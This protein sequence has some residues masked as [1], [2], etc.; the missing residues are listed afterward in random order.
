VPSLLRGFSAPVNLTLS[1]SDRDL[2]FLMANDSDLFNRWQ[3]ANTYATRTLVQIVQ[4]MTAGKRSTRGASYAKALGAT[5]RNP[6]LEPAYRAE[7]LRLPSQSDIARE[8]ARDVDPGLIFRAHR[9]LAKVIGATL[10]DELEQVYREM[11]RDKTFSPDAAA[12]G[13]RALRNSALAMLMAR[14]A[15][16]DQK[17]LAAHYFNATNM[18]DQAFALFHL[19]QEATPDRER[20]L[21][22]FYDRW[23][24]DHLVIDMWFSAQAQSAL[25]SALTDVEALTKHPLFSLTA[26]NKVRAL[27][28][29]FALMNPVQFN[30]PDGAGYMFVINQVLA[31][32]GFNPQ[33]AARML[34]AFRSWRTLEP[35]RRRLARKALTKVAKSANLSRDVFEIVSRTL[36]A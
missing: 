9:Q 32:D 4:A 2:E 33:I 26:P 10:G 19:A 23:K 17:R 31:I 21:A 11:G 36:E 27:V 6:D 15:G 30:R 3:A 35:E 5:L 29:N 14:G 18:T 8:I 16:G 25:P 24:D 28:G 34:A 20:A 13:R 12:A 7:L 1:L 22:H